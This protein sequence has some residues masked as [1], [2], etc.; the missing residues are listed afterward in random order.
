MDTKTARR[1]TFDVDYVVVTEENISEV[2]VWCNGTV[3][4]EEP[5]R[6]IKI[7]D[8]NAMNTRQ[9]KAFV[10]DYVLKSGMTFKSYG[11]K[12]FYK[13]F[14]DV[15]LEHAGAPS[16]TL[17]VARSAKTGQFVTPTEALAHPETTVVEEIPRENLGGLGD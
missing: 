10:G 16:E 12:S 17:K 11:K 1:K 4:G 7:V 13:S 5:D 8:K 9:T 6:F 14:D 2:A 15:V 3:G